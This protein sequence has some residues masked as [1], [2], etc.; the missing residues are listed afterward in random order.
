[1]HI[2]IKNKFLYYKDYKVKCAVGKRGINIKRREGD[3]IT[4]KGEFKIKSV[5]YRRDRIKLLK[6]KLK[7]KVIKR[8]MGWCDDPRSKDYN[9]LIRFPFKYR[10]EKLFIKENIYDILLVLDFNMNPV[11][12]KKVVQYFYIFQRRT[13]AKPKAA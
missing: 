5:Y 1:M 6:T 3:F 9:K 8:N 2:I 10:A 7:K 11:V 12:K 4:P 13:L